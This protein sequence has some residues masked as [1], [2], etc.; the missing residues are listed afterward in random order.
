LIWFSTQ[1]TIKLRD[2]HPSINSFLGPTAP[3]ELG[4][5]FMATFFCVFLKIIEG[6]QNPGS[7]LPKG[8]ALFDPSGQRWRDG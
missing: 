4:I 2:I 6:G 7:P 5:P 8:G 1:I 3:K